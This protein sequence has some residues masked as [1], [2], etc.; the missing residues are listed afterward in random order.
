M[1]LGQLLAELSAPA[2]TA[3]VG[4]QVGFMYNRYFWIGAV[5]TFPGTWAG[6][7]I[8]DRLHRAA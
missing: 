5:L 3:Q 6:S 8:R 1:A 2:P 4:F 7:A